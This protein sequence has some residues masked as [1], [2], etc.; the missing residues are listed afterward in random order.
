MAPWQMA[1]EGFM[2]MKPPFIWISGNSEQ[3]NRV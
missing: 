1:Y 2:L 3:P